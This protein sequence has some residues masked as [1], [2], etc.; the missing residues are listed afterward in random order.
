[1]GQDQIPGQWFTVDMQKRQRFNRIVMDNVWA[2][3]DSPAGYTIHVS[4]DGLNWGE[5]VA[6][7][8]GERWGI[9]TAMFK[10]VTARYIKIEQTGQAKQFWSIFELDVYK[11]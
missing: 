4:D 7:G 6:S 9:T 8:K 10:P 1:M 2:V 5:P 3:Y 11:P